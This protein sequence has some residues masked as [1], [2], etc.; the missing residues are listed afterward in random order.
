MPLHKP[1]RTGWLLSASACAGS[2]AIFPQAF[3]NTISPAL[4]MTARLW[5]LTLTA[6]RIAGSC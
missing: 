1:V 6:C 3:F 5:P 2:D 4:Q